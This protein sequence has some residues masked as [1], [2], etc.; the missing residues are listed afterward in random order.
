M[1][2]GTGHRPAHPGR[3]RR[4]GTCEKTQT[5]HLTCE[6]GPPQ[7]RRTGV[8]TWVVHGR[9]RMAGV[10]PIRASPWYGVWSR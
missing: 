2:G 1:G 3:Q 10:L 4:A 7:A 6:D 5:V 8:P 9:G